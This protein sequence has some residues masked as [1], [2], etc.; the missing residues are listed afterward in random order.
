ML[1]PLKATDERVNTMDERSECGRP[2]IMTTTYDVYTHA[3]PSVDVTRRHGA[4]WSTAVCIY[5]V[6]VSIVGLPKTRPD[7][8]S[9]RIVLWYPDDE[10]LYT[11][12]SV[13]LQEYTTGQ[14]IAFV[15]SAY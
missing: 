13:G 15:E 12:T 5:R 2:R 3:L 14:T 4:V 10:M 11:V 6:V 9:V 1:S 8:T 7:L